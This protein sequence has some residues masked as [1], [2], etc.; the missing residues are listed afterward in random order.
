MNQSQKQ[1]KSADWWNAE[2]IENGLR[3][4]HRDFF[5]GDEANLPLRFFSYRKHIPQDLRRSR[6]YPPYLAVLRRYGSLFEAWQSLG[7]AVRFRPNKNI[8]ADITGESFGWLTALDYSHSAPG[9]GRLWHCRCRCGKVTL[10]AVK[11]LLRGRVVS[12][13]CYNRTV[14]AKKRGEKLRLDLTGQRFGRLTALA[15][16]GKKGGETFWRALCDCGKEF[17]VRVSSLTSRGTRSC[18]CLRDEAGTVNL[19]NYR[20]EKKTVMEKIPKRLLI[21]S[22]SVR[23]TETEVCPAIERYL[24][25]AFYVVRRFLKTNPAN[26]VEIWILSAKYGLIN[27]N[28]RTSHYDA[29]MT[30]QRAGELKPKLDRQFSILKQIS[31]GNSQ[32]SEVFCHLPQNYREALGEQIKSLRQKTRV[33]VSIGRP[34]EKLSELKNWLKKEARNVS[35]YL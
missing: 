29:A 6:L 7:F 1:I 13:G 20:K 24:S 5:Q 31:F 34:G 30:P 28:W 9:S 18:G 21:L 19:E 25:P 17:D 16:A 33:R 4:Y 22:C 11:N 26:D 2:R 35:S 14:S 27:Q 8:A 32:P 10:A 23:K 3:R 15:R 12:C